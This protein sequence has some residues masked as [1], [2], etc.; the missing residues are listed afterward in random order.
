MV[1]KMISGEVARPRAISF[2]VA[3]P[4][5]GTHAILGVRDDEDENF[6]DKEQGSE[7]D[8]R[9]DQA[10]EPRAF[11]SNTPEADQELGGESSSAPSKNP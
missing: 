8:S 5:S 11:P 7:V 6:E 2:D 10:V 1:N 9:F 4:V 3:H